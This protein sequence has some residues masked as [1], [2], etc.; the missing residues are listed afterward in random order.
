MQAPHD[1]RPGRAPTWRSRIVG[2]GDADPQTLVAHPLNWRAH[3]RNQRRA[4]A[5]VLGEVGWVQD[6]I[7][8]R[9]TGRILDGH[10]RVA[11]ALER[12]EAPV[13]IVEVDLRE[14]EERVILATFDPLGAMANGDADA[15]Q[16]LLARVT[17]E[18]AAV[19][20]LLGRLAAAHPATPDLRADPDAVPEPPPE[21]VS[22]P[23]DCWTCGPHRVWC[24]DAQD[25]AAVAGLFPDGPAGWMWTD[26]P[27]GIAYTGKT[28]A[29]LTIAGDAADG[30]E[31][32]LHESFRAA[33]AV[34]APGTSIF[35][36]HPAEPQS[37][38]FGAAFLAAGWHWHQ[39][40]TWVKDTL[41][42]G[43]SDFHYRHEPILYGWKPGRAHGWY[44]GRA[45]DSLF[46]LPRP[47]ASREHPT[48][49]PVALIAAQLAL[50]T[51]PGDLGYDPFAG[52]G[53]TLIAAEQL[54][55]R[56]VA[57]E[58]GPRYADVI[59]Q[60][61]QNATGGTATL[62]DGGRTFAQMQEVRH[63]R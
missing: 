14:D 1:N 46:A 40:L 3:P 20:D 9:R 28:P 17:A 49:K 58:I 63:R 50:T 43:H 10:L 44:G 60:R 53:S 41:V 24:G 15:V 30:L 38:G 42:L 34:L 62:A 59:V 13:P 6:V 31:P 21:P 55:R 52:S 4:M 18:E 51:R 61:W 26:P 56:C 35:V 33:D 8:N 2:H 36:A 32:L 23:G 22:R 11:L 54:G 48:M 47:A 16:D 12:G 45:E 27:Y 29:G 25:A 5:G 7:V 19:A 37:L 39:T 57:V